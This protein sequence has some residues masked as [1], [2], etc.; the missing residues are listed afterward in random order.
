[1]TGAVK[2]SGSKSIEEM[3]IFSFVNENIIGKWIEWK[4]ILGKGQY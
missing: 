2:K 1:V 4:R 3:E